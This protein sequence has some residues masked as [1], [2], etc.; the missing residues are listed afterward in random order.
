[1]EEKSRMEWERWKGWIREGKE[2]RAEKMMTV[3]GVDIE[4]L[5]E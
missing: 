4:R 2:E 1:M 5:E 3:Y